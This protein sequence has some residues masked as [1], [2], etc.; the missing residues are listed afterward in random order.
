MQIRARRFT[1]IDPGNMRLE[2]YTI[3][4][5][6]VLFSMNVQQLDMEEINF[7]SH[8]P[9]YSVYCEHCT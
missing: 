2:F 3:S 5:Q 4:L 7:L 6:G 9:L 8:S 1:K